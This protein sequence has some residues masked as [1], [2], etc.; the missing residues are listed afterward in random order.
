[1]IEV[2][3]MKLRKPLK[4]E[5]C[6]VTF[7]LRP[8]R[9][10]GLEFTSF[11]AASMAALETFPFIVLNVKIPP[12]FTTSGFEVTSFDAPCRGVNVDAS[13]S[14][15]ITMMNAELIGELPTDK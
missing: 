9:I 4:L 1:M 13:H 5:S 2:P 14:K 12:I 6:S 15:Y 3:P 11:T 7:N 10:C 8:P